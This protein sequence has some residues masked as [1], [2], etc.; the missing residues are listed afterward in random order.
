MK[1]L[2]AGASFLPAYG[3]PAVSV[4]S[5]GNALAELGVTVGLW[6]PDN[7][8]SY[9][10]IPLHPSILLLEGGLAEALRQLGPPDLIHDNGIWLPHNNQLAR[11]ASHLGAS[12][13]VS[14]R[15]MLEPWSMRQRWAKKQLAWQ[16]YQK[17]DL[18]RASCLHATGDM[19]AEN[20]RRLGL[21]TPVCVIPNGV[22]LPA[23]EAYHR[24]SR[25]RDDRRV[26]FLSRIHPKKGLPLLI[27]AWSRLDPKG[28]TLNI[29]GTDD[30]G[31]LAEIRR[32][33]TLLGLREQVV[34]LGP[35]AGEQKRQA[36]LDADLF[37]LPTYSE[38]FG[39]VVAE[40]MAHGLPVVTTKGAPW[41]VLQEA[42]CG[43]WVE[44]TL[45]GVLEGLQDALAHSP[46]ALS[47]MGALGREVV[48]RQFGWLQ[49]GRDML[50]EYHSLV[51]P[52][53][54]SSPSNAK[55][56]YD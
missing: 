9:S 33:V 51:S 21:K 24:T 4:P 56:K 22:D 6:A 41:G 3:G 48:A 31:H 52:K 35:L 32:M 2:L 44:P 18:A 5:L 7:S 39:I 1:I 45:K 28:W 19:E 53:A 13:V 43:W 49:V 37:V 30:D 38:N 14:L 10:P 46:E 40:A 26:L 20:V 15:G 29:A 11:L 42:Q 50:A 17:R 54:K 55:R 27:E 23:I 8:T 25:R 36:F 34:F 12:R 16:L 47:Q